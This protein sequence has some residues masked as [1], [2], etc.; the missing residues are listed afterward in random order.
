MVMMRDDDDSSWWRI[1]LFRPRI[2]DLLILAIGTFCLLFL[3]ETTATASASTTT[4][5]SNNKNNVVYDFEKLTSLVQ[6]LNVLENAAEQTLVGFYEPHLCSFSV[7]PGIIMGSSS[8]NQKKVCVTSTCYALLTMLLSSPNVYESV[9]VMTSAS[10]HDDDDKDNKKADDASVDDDVSSSSFTS[11]SPV[12]TTTTTIIPIHRVVQTLLASKW[13]QDDLFQVPLVLYTIFTADRDRSLL[14][15]AITTDNNTTRERLQNMLWTVLRACPDPRRASQEHSDYISY[16]ICKVLAVLQESIIMDN[17]ASSSS[18]GRR[19]S[20]SRAAA[21]TKN[22]TGGSNNNSKVG[23]SS[24]GGGLPP[25]LLPDGFDREI[26]PA[27]RHC[28]QVSSRTLC[29]MLAYR[30][31]GD[32][33][34]FDVMRLAYSLLTYLR[35]NTCLMRCGVAGR[36]VVPGQGP[37]TE[38]KVAPLNQKL[39]AAAL[40]AFFE[41]Q[42]SDG[43]WDKGQPIYKNFNRQGRQ[44]E[45]AFVFPGTGGCLCMRKGNSV[46]LLV[47]IHSICV[48]LYANVSHFPIL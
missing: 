12:A 25:Q 24:S 19:S 47:G 15:A 39:V 40:K 20:T 29:Q 10:S 44:L 35:S 46:G 42:H 30:V 18:R 26:F 28:S 36:E 32:T 6:R 7:K 23:G 5:S 3:Q 9:M 13:R 16:Q 4:S 1:R 33:N 14:R 41:E 22:N 38:S 27:L 34:K 37:T 2:R 17:A 31:A 11:S 43:L 8:K 48:P 45:N 21:K